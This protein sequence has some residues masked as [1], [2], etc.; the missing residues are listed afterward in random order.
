MKKEEDISLDDALR[1]I[2]DVVGPAGKGFWSLFAA[3]ERNVNGPNSV[4]VGLVM[5]TP[6]GKLYDLYGAVG[7]PEDLTGCEAYLVEALR[8]SGWP[9][10]P[11]EEETRIRLE[12]MGQD[13]A[14]AILKKYRE[15][16]D[17]IERRREETVPDMS[18]DE[19][20]ASHPHRCCMSWY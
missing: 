15:D 3:R 4:R 9:L 20:R 7:G 17:R 13:E 8:R 18:V 14:I 11:S 10:R 19:H 2:A 16:M 1:L 5:R 6:D 12:I